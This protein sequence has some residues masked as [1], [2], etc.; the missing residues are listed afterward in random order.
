MPGYL[1]HSHC[2]VDRYNVKHFNSMHS[3]AVAVSWMRWHANEKGW[4]EAIKFS[5]TALY[6]IYDYWIKCVAEKDLTISSRWVEQHG[7]DV[8]P[9]SAE[10]VRAVDVGPGSKEMDALS[11][12]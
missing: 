7:G 2:S 10:F 1:G 8:P 6:G 5:D 11:G 3:L 9:T 4:T 12:W